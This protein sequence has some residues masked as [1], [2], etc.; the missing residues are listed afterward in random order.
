MFVFI[1][2][3]AQSLSKC[4]T[5]SRKKIQPVIVIIIIIIMIGRRRIVILT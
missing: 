3:F 4:S 1:Q 2:L 5:G